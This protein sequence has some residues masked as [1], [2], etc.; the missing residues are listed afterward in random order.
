MNPRSCCLGL[1]T[2]STLLA[3]V[4]AQGLF[5]QYG[6]VVVAA[7]GQVPGLPVGLT[8]YQTSNGLDTPA[9]DQNGTILVRS[10]FQDT[11]GVGGLTGF[12]DR[13]YLLGRAS[14]DI[15]LVVRADD[16]APGI[17]GATLRGS[18]S[19]G[20]SQLNSTPRISPFGEILFFQSSIY[21]ATTPANTPTASDS[22]VFYGPVGGLTKLTREG[23]EV[24][25]FGAG[26]GINWG[27][28][29]TGWSG[30]HS[31]INASGQIAM[32]TQLSGTGITTANDVVLVS[33]VPPAI[34]VALREG[35]TM[36]AG[37][38]LDGTEVVT[39]PSTSFFTASWLNEA[40]QI[41]HDIAF[42][43][44]V[45]T[46][47]TQNNLGLCITINTSHFVI[48]REGMQA[49]GFAP[50][51]LVSDG[52]G[53]FSPYLATQ[54]FTR[55][56]NTTF[57]ASLF[58]GGATITPGLNDRALYYGGLGGWTLIAQKGDAAP[59]LPG[60]TF[61]D[62]ADASVRCN[63]AGTVVF[64]SNLVGT[65]GGTADDTA[66]FFGPAGGPLTMIAREGDPVVATGLAGGPWVFRA[67]T[68]TSGT[69]ILNDAG[70]EGR[71]FW[72]PSIT[73]GSVIKTVQ[74][75]Y[76]SALGW[77]CVLDGTETI[78]TGLG[79]GPR[80]SF[81]SGG[82]TDPNGDGAGAFWYNNNG[83]WVATLA[84]ASPVQ[85]VLARGHVGSLIA[86]PSSVPVAGG[87]PHN[88]HVD[89]GPSQAGQLYLVLATGSGSRPGFVSP[90]GG[91]KVPLNPLD[92]SLSTD[93]WF[94]L[95]LNNSNSIVWPGTL[96]F[97]D[98]NGK[99]TT[100]ASFVMPPGFPV[101]LGTTL[102]HA[103]VA[104]D[105][106]F[107]LQTTY[108]SEPSAVKLY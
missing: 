59:G 84:I 55:S 23:E 79:A 87:V 31:H 99:N 12:N 65:S 69:P 40:G 67:M 60:V 66:L 105:I 100:P 103:V 9:I 1:L 98:A 50:G 7:G 36:A 30:R 71:L 82:L 85:G 95:S 54:S 37:V 28:T 18:S 90:F 52:A 96:G 81:N 93:L 5:A 56:G 106:T 3:P 38:N 72:Q 101:F 22:A 51:V 10:R 2:L 47:T 75:T 20:S 53:N 6:E 108:A 13:G 45:G 86:E 27:Q 8:F 63:D 78:T 4:A 68:G 32:S 70:T 15:T 58:D 107:G 104:F 11:G 61:G 41:L 64:A 89:C 46:V 19:V 35:D 14:G 74:L 43:T 39:A 34:Y 91:Q 73:D 21:D 97:L 102:H 24:P 25:F 29:S 44:G 57:R 80:T 88:F 94:D 77:Q 42:T 17:P 49:P 48:V 76:S 26:S 16:P 83:D 92:L 62:F 33:G